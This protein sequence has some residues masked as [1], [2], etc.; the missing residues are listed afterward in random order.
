M[1]EQSQRD[2]TIEVLLKTLEQRA[3]E[4]ETPADVNW[5][6]SAKNSQWHCASRA[7]GIRDAIH[8]I[9]LAFA[10]RV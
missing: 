3:K 7:A 10:P 5:P 8:A 4:I 6:E 2:E 9:K 1:P